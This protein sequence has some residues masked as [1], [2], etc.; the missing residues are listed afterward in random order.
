MAS[1]D[2]ILPNA[3][4]FFPVVELKGRQGDQARGR[5]NLDGWIRGTFRHSSEMIGNIEERNLGKRWD[6]LQVGRVRIQRDS[7]Y[8]K[9]DPW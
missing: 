2:H 3:G 9:R 6:F 5:E 1:G 8:G 7:F 4:N